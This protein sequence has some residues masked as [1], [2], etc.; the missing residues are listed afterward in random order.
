MLSKGLN[1]EIGY[2]V[3][4]SNGESLTMMHFNKVYVWRL[5]MEC[6]RENRKEK[7]M[8]VYSDRA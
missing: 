5:I 8:I 4:L 2:E 3:F 6:L 1:G 7:F